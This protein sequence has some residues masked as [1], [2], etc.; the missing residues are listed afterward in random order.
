[1]WVVKLG[2]SLNGDPSLPQWLRA[3]CTLGRGR[4]AVAPGGGRFAD[5]VREAQRRWGFAD[6]T[7]HNMAI[8]A[9][10]QTALMLRALNP[11][12]EAAST[13]AEIRNV[14]R[15]GGTALWLPVA[16]LREHADSLTNW[17]VTSDSLALWL[18]RHLNAERL[19]IV[20]SCALEPGL[21]LRQWGDAGVLDASF[22][23]RAEGAGFAIELM[24]RTDLSRMRALLVGSADHAA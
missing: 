24:R 18:A 12:L 3:L 13:E 23:S 4:V 10:M 5:Q 21:S 1:M 22:A 17:D 19:V 11:A 20:K 16:L 15:H 8:L 2:G 9:M 14:L 6:L 7:A